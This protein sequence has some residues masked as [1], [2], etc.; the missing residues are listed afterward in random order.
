MF[1]VP[2]NEVTMFIFRVYV[3]LTANFGCFLLVYIG[4]SK[5]YTIIIAFNLVKLQKLVLVSGF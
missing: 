5:K 3:S 2:K 1:T 4:H